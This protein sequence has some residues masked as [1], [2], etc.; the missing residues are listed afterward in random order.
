MK[1]KESDKCEVCGEIDFIEHMFFQCRKLIGFWRKVSN[2]IE[3][4]TSLQITLSETNVLFGIT[5]T[6]TSTTQAYINI[7]NHLILIGKVCISKA[8][9]GKIKN[10]NIFLDRVLEIRNKYLK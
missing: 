7:I 9:Y 1:I 4:K 5:K 3:L 2:V 6:D 10:I 8:K